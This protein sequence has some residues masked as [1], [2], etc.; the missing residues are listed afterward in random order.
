M[1]DTIGQLAALSVAGTGTLTDV[2]T[3]PGSKEASVNIRVTNSADVDTDI[4]VAHI[5]MT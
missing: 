4:I 1:A 3:V 5:K 2:Y